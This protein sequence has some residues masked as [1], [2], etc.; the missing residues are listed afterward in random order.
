MTQAWARPLSLDLTTA[1]TTPA[2]TPAPSPDHI[3]ALDHSLCFDECTLEDQVGGM[4]T[5]GI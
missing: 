2:P 4:H 1:P 3:L 5:L